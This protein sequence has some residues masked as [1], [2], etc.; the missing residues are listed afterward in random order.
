MT[1]P[2][3]TWNPE[4]TCTAREVGTKIEAHFAGSVLE[5]VERVVGTMGTRTYVWK[6][7]LDTNLR[8]TTGLRSEE[9]TKPMTEHEL[10]WVRTH[11]MPL[12]SVIVTGAA[13]DPVSEA[14]AAA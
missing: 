2:A 11:R 9:P 7:D 13:N 12:V 10:E 4:T 8:S 5:V 14:A 6:Y 3:L 1:R